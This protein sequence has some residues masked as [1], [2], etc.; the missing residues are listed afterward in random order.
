MD[1]TERKP[2]RNVKIRRGKTLVMP[3]VLPKALIIQRIIEQP[4]NTNEQ[5]LETIEPK[6]P[7]GENNVEPPKKN[8]KCS[9]KIFFNFLNFLKKN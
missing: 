5:P 4:I 8:N 3:L 6:D 7:L 2:L 1:I 9:I